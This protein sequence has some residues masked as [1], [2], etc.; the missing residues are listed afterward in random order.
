MPAEKELSESEI[1]AQVVEKKN[2]VDSLAQSYAFNCIDI[3]LC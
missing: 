1:K 3:P 2:Q